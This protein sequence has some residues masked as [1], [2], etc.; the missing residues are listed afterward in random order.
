MT[1]R[2][3]CG[4]IAISAL[5]NRWFINTKFLKWWDTKISK[6]VLIN[7]DSKTSL[8]SVHFV[9]KSHRITGRGC[10]VDVTIVTANDLMTGGDTIHTGV[11]DENVVLSPLGTD[12]QA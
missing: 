5:L 7:A 9:L 4:H 11:T 10:I 3:L 6:L 1:E 12:H 2:L 8:S